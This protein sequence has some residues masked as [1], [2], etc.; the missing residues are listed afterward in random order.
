MQR[1][2]KPISFIAIRHS[3][4]GGLEQIA[5]TSGADNLIVEQLRST[6]VLI[7]VE[8]TAAKPVDSP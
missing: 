8:S 7:G 6:C 5:W 4:V 2:V 3:L 1:F